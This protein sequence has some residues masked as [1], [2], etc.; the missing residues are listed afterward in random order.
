MARDF[1]RAFYNS[2][3]WKLCRKSFIANRIT[4]DGGMCQ[5]CQ[6]DLGYIVDHIEELK[7]DNINDPEITLNDENLQYLCLRCHNKKTFGNSEGAL[8]EGL[9]FDE[10]GDLIQVPP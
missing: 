4:V 8:V 6:R 10:S 7:P 2:K 3:E 1:A 5:H 9:I